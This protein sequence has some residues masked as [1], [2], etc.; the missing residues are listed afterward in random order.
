MK[1]RLLHW[2]VKDKKRAKLLLRCYITYEVLFNKHKHFVMISLDDEQFRSMVKNRGEAIETDE[3]TLL[4]YGMQQFQSGQL[5]KLASSCI[6]ET[7][8]QLQQ[9]EFEN[10][11]EKQLSKK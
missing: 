2:F 7:D 9:L 3:I 10:M 8:L 4:H 11:V 1:N 6:H 5:I